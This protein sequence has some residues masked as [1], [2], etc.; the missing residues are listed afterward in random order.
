MELL[1]EMHQWKDGGRA[2]HRRQVSIKP[3]YFPWN[4]PRQQ[5]GTNGADIFH[6]EPLEHKDHGDIG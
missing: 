5:E 3:S 2:G 1:V 4:V 6:G